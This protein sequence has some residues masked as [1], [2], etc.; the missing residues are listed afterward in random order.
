M[1]RV[2][3]MHAPAELELDHNEFDVCKQF[4]SMTDEA[5]DG[6]LRSFG[7]NP[8]KVAL[9]ATR[10]RDLVASAAEAPAQRQV[11]QDAGRQ[12]QEIDLPGAATWD[13]DLVASNFTLSASWSRLL[14]RTIG[15]GDG[16][17]TWLRTVHPLDRALVESALRRAIEDL[18]AF[19]FESVFRRVFRDNESRL[20]LSRSKII[21][22]ETGRVISM[23]G[24]DTDVTVIG[25]FR[26]VLDPILEKTTDLS[27]ES[28]FWKLVHATSTALGVSASV[29]EF[30]ND[31]KVRLLASSDTEFFQ[32]YGEYDIRGTPCENIA[33]SASRL[34]VISRERYPAFIRAERYFGI[35]IRHRSGGLLG[36]LCC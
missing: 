30:V 27:G 31:V 21:R 6:C 36:T 14:D 10:L 13:W 32:G 17:D 22:G 19:E 2:I 5:L 28:Y 4:L 8:S 9:A 7:A 1:E 26:N 34:L 35:P 23:H 33:S 12:G 16:L 24:I 29:A 25:E 11:G 15:T 3:E 18:N 20:F